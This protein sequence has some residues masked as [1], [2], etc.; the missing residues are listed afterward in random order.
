MCGYLS[1]AFECTKHMSKNMVTDKTST[2]LNLSA[3]FTPHWTW[4]GFSHASYGGYKCGRCTT[5]AGDNCTPRPWALFCSQGIDGYGW[6]VWG[7]SAPTCHVLRFTLQGLKLDSDRL[8]LVANE[9][10]WTLVLHWVKSEMR[11]TWDN[12]LVVLNDCYHVCLERSK[13]R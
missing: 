7:R 5:A 6:R 3:D 2:R 1:Q 11:F 12:M 4:Y 9:T 10:A 8:L 13:P